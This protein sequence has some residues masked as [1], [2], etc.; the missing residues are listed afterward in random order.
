MEKKAI[1]INYTIDMQLIDLQVELHKDERNNDKINKIV[2]A[3][4]NLGTKL[5]DNR[6][7][8]FLKAKDVLTAAQKKALPHSFL[9][10]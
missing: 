10:M 2:F 3:I 8:H 5:M 7:V 9:M 6:V 4:T 1:D